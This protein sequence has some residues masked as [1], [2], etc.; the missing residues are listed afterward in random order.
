[1]LIN[2]PTSQVYTGTNCTATVNGQNINCQVLNSSAILLQNVQGNAVY[3]IDGLFNQKSFSLNAI[4]DLVQ[5]NLGYPYTRASTIPTTTT[6]VDPKLTLGTITLQTVQSTN[7]VL[8]NP[9]T[10]SYNFTI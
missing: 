9:T 2:F 8:L 1:M 3:I 5:V 6:Y 7:N 10:V 4:H